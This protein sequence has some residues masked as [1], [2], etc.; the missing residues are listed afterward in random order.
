MTVSGNSEEGREK[1]EG[2]NH[3]AAH[4]SPFALPPLRPI[5]IFG[6]T[7]DPIHYGHLRMAEEL[8]DSLALDI[9]RFIPAG[10]PPHRAS[11]RTE[12]KHRLEM[13]RLAIAGNPRFLLDEREVREPRASFTF[14]TL[15]SLRQELGADQP[16]WLLMGT[17]AFLGLPTWKEWRQLFSL[18]HIAVAHRPGY[19]LTQSDMLPD[20]LRR[21]LEQR[22]CDIPPAAPSGSIFLKPVTALDISATAIRQHLSSGTSARYLLPDPVLDHIQQHHL[23]TAS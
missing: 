22:R 19:K 4:P 17:D 13:T 6:G 2:Q 18:A 7:F 16:L 9:V 10:Q 11:P 12:A 15:T 14:D 1:G 20:P 23:Y 8:A 5:G 21:E 3:D